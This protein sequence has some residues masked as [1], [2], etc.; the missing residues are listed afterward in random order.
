MNGNVL[1]NSGT[2]KA[3]RRD[4]FTLI[5]L[6]VVIAIL[7]L[8]LSLLM[9]SLQMAKEVAKAAL[10]L[11]NQKQCGTAFATYANDWDRR[12]VV[13]WQNTGGAIALWPTLYS[14]ERETL[15]GFQGQNAYLPPSGIFGCPSNMAY[16]N[17]LSQGYYGRTNYGYGMYSNTLAFP[18][19]VN[20]QQAMGWNFSE[21]LTLPPDSIGGTKEHF[22]E[23][24]VMFRISRPSD[25]VWLADTSSTRN[26]EFGNPAAQGRMVAA[27]NPH[28]ESFHTSRIH[29]VHHNARANVLFYDGH[30][31]P[32]DMLALYDSASNVRALYDKDRNF[33]N[34]P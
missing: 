32:M 21:K 28:T 3:V 22:V 31:A 23:L 15:S 18:P 12:T 17:D 5:E 34:L 33:I 1:R 25:I 19:S 11:S 7:A 24:H 6:L 13:M 4:G 20:H 8:L 16:P 9:P 26:W 27:F 14:G 29:L 30:A 2:S 10:C